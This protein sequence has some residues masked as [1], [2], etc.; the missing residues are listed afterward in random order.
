M[1]DPG[2]VSLSQGTGRSAL[3]IILAKLK[4]NKL[5]LEGQ[6]FKSETETNSRSAHNVQHKER[7]HVERDQS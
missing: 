3:K 7:T 5:H 6:I 1:F 2:H 4:V